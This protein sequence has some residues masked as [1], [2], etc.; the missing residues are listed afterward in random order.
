MLTCPTCKGHMKP[1]FTGFFCPNDCDRTPRP[2]KSTD[3]FI[4]VHDGTRWQVWLADSID[5]VLPL[6]AQRGWWISKSDNWKQTAERLINQYHPQ[7]PGWNFHNAGMAPTSSTQFKN[8]L[9]I[10]FKKL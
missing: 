7:P 9:L 1:L 4:H 8:Q 6:E 3:A 5:R 10:L 2:L